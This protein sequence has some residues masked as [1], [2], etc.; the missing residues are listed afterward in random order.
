MNAALAGFDLFALV[1]LFASGI[2]ALMRGFVREALTVTALVAAALAALWTRPVFAP[3][4]QSVIGSALF[5]N[6]I[7]MGIVFL[8]VYLAVS[9]VTGPLTHNVKQGEDVPVLDRALGFVFGLARGLVLLG[10]LVLVF[11]NTLP[12]A[13]PN[14]LTGSRVYPLAEA[15][16]N[17]LQSLAPESSWVNA[18]KAADQ[19]QQSVDEDPIGRLIERT[20]EDEDG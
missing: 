16:A 12:G 4:T 17:L 5:A 2:M 11:K 14:W 20:N 15:S 9:F 1:I 13:T 6:L 10:L 18:K 19:P 7:S 3:L 8:L